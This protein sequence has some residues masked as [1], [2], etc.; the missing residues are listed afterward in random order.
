MNECALVSLENF[1]DMPSLEELILESNRLGGAELVHLSHLKGLKWLSLFENVIKD[2]DD[3][4]AL[5]GLPLEHLEIIGNDV[6]KSAEYRKRLFEVIPT[7]QIIDGWGRDG[8]EV[9]VSRLEGDE[10][11]GTVN[12]GRNV[13]ALES[14]NDDELDNY[15]DEDEEGR[16]C[17][18]M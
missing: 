14:E 2:V 17:F 8:K 1:P 6:T 16:H 4:K 18:R 15:D 5:K 13:I 9:E 7:L 11:D 10:G 3:F 12:Q